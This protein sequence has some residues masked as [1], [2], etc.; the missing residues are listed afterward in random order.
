MFALSTHT[1]LCPLSSPSDRLYPDRPPTPAS[2]SGLTQ[3]PACSL[4]HSL[5]G[6]SMVLGPCEL[7][8]SRQGRAAEQAGYHFLN[9]PRP[10]HLFPAT[11]PRVTFTF[12]ARKAA[13]GS[14]VLSVTETPSGVPT[15]TIQ[16]AFPHPVWMALSDVID[17]GFHI[18]F[19]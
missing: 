11:Q 14:W 2:L 4:S 18:N 19:N 15:R 7:G 17:I 8:D 9:R 5:P 16:S 10:G 13:A 6:H 1:P 3:S 12:L